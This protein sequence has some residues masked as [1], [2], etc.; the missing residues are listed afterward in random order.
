MICPYA[1]NRKTVTQS[2]IEY[3]ENGNQ[4]AWVEIQNNNASFL[5]CQKEY[6]AVFRDGRC[7]YNN[8]K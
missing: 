6:C 2:K 4:T 5:K 3:D 7:C 1:V 8:A